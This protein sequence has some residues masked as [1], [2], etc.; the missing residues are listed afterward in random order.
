[1]KQTQNQIHRKT[2]FS[3]KTDPITDESILE[4]RNEN[5]NKFYHHNGDDHVFPCSMRM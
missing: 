3:E 5:D 4:T 2:Y 1:M